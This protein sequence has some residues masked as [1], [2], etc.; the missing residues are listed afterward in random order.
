MTPIDALGARL[1]EAWIAGAFWARGH[2]RAT[3]LTLFPFRAAEAGRWSPATLLL[4]SLFQPTPGAL[5]PVP[6]APPSGPPFIPI[7]PVLT[8]S[9]L[10]ASVLLP[11][12][13]PPGVALRDLVLSVY[14]LSARSNNAF[15]G[16]YE[17][18]FDVLRQFIW[19]GEIPDPYREDIGLTAEQ[20]ASAQAGVLES[21]SGIPV[22]SLTNLVLR[23]RPDSFQGPCVLLESAVG[24]PGIVALFDGNGTAYKF[25]ESFDLPA[26]TLVAVEGFTLGSS[27]TACGG[28]AIEVAAAQ[29]TSLPPVPLV[30]ANGNLL[31]DDW[32]LLFLGGLADGP[33]ADSDKDG[34][35]DVQEMQEGT[36]P[37]DPGNVPPVA[38]L[39]LGEPE[40]EISLAP[41][42]D[43]EVHWTHAPAFAK[44]SGPA[45]QFALLGAPSIGGPFTLLASRP[46]ESDGDISLALPPP[47]DATR[48]FRLRLQLVRR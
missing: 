38:P 44:G 48:F 8:A 42:G 12:D 28:S 31:A 32:E 35:P 3:N 24:D 33:F 15:P 30:D 10:S 47:T 5:P 29:V 25:P 40:L 22:R 34:F 6:D 46:A 41:S 14:A 1:A 21:L 37:L 23:I 43:I 7:E 27:T 4:Q 16:R 17:P 18:P 13:Q 26:G 2:P 20:V 19:E 45:W 39:E 9:G 36:D 11:S